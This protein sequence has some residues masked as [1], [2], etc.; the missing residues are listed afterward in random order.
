MFVDG[1]NENLKGKTINAISWSVLLQSSSQL[2]N[3]IIGVFIARLLTPDD[4]GL[5]AMVLV[6]VSFSQLFADLGFAAALIQREKIENIHYISCFWLNVFIGLIL[7]VTMFL[8]SDWVA[9]FYERTELL[10][11]SQSLSILFLIVSAS[12][13]PR[14]KLVRNLNHKNIGIIEIVSNLTAGISAILLALNGFSYWSLVFQLILLNVM[15]LVLIFYI[16][17]MPFAFLF[18]FSELKKLLS[19]SST[20][21]TTKLIREGTSQLDKLL[22]GKYIDSATLGLYSK[23]YSLMLFPIQNISRVITNV[24]FPTFSKIQKDPDRV[25]SIFLKC[26]GCISL[27]TSPILLGIATVAPHLIEVIFGK[28]WLGMTTYLQF[29]CVLGL[30]LSVA[31][32][33]GS[34][35][36]GLG[37]PDLQLKV[38][39]FTQPLKIVCLGIGV[40]YGIEGLMFGFF[41]SFI[42]SVFVTWSVAMRLINMHIGHILKAILPT[43]L[44]SFLMAFTTWILDNLLFFN[45][46]IVLR[47][48]S[49]IVTGVISYALFTHLFSPAAY[50]ELKMIVSQKLSKRPLK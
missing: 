32:V 4:F 9:R 46:S 21:F 44:I 50:K 28:Q 7:S 30:I 20:V 10:G 41:V 39:L 45:L 34:V 38:N 40:T 29:F 6:F 8:A 13:V 26:I 14:A 15:R 43:M 11:I 5:V 3:F 36:L 24:M 35:Y 19:F 18:S 25:G 22:V 33:T 2:L 48:F 17:N 47:L 42:I 49:C 1:K 12:S 16:S 23:A 27:L 37:R 31:T